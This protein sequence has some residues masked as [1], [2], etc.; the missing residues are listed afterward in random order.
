MKKRFGVDVGIIQYGRWYTI[1]EADSPDEA[2]ELALEEYGLDDIKFHS[3]EQN[4]LEVEELGPKSEADPEFMS[5]EWWANL[6]SQKETRRMTTALFPN[7]NEYG[8]YEFGAKLPEGIVIVATD[9]SIR[10]IRKAGIPN[11]KSAA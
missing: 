9:G 2:E 6:C 5:D 4:I 11:V 10:R 3:S 8:N 1:V 7:L